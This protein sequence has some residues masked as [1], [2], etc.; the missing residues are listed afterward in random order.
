MIHI[1]THPNSFHSDEIVAIALMSFVDSIEI[2]R[3]RSEL[4][5]GECEMLVDV[6]G[7]YDPLNS[8]YDHHQFK[9]DDP[10]YGLSS[11]GLVYKDMRP[12]FKTI[13]DVE[14]LDAFIEAVDARDTR[15]GYNESNVYEPVFDAIT[16]LNYIDPTSHKEQAEMFDVLVE[17]VSDII[18]VLIEKMLEHMQK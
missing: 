13:G 9:K 7:E 17:R 16:S 18:D 1:G 14:D 11:A 6:G 15:V 2:T 4:V 5:L 8:K 12:Y 10:F 3:S